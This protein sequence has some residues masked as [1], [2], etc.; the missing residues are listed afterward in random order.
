MLNLQLER[1]LRPDYRQIDTPWEPQPIVWFSTPFGTSRIE[2]AA[3]AADPEATHLVREVHVGARF[4]EP[5]LGTSIPMGTTKDLLQRATEHFHLLEALTP[6]RVAPTEWHAF[7][8]EGDRVH[9]LARVAIIDGMNAR[10][11]YDSDETFEEVLA[12]Y[13]DQPANG[14]L[15]DVDRRAQYILGK[16]R[17]ASLGEPALYLVDIE[18]LFD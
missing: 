14:L 5:M 17:V 15:R 18:P 13:I 12:P 9:V 11:F 16:P 3:A 10:S 4:L 7:K 8:G 6:V 1:P 2:L